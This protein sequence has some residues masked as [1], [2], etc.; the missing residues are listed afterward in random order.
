MANSNI[1]AP[2]GH[3]DILDGQALARV[4]P[5]DVYAMKSKTRD[6][7]NDST[8]TP[9]TDR[10]DT[11]DEVFRF[12]DLPRELRDQIYR[13]LLVSE[14]VEQDFPNP[15][16]DHDPAESKLMRR[17]YPAPDARGALR[18]QNFRLQSLTIA[19]LFYKSTT[20]FLGKLA[21]SLGRSDGSLST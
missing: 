5:S 19:F 8:Q 7:H 18:S 13:Y 4:P 12:L 15:A 3:V 16:Y 21:L 6:L 9:S 1:S 2:S 10:D 14:H 20:K 11:A 17:A